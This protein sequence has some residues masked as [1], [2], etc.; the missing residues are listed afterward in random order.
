MCR[1][2]TLVSVSTDPHNVVIALQLALSQ[3]KNIRER[4]QFL[5]VATPCY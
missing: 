2:A 4:T 3:M 1:V 5:F